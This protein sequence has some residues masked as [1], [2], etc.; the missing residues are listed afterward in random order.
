MASESRHPIDPQIAERFG[1][2]D[3]PV[4]DLETLKLRHLQEHLENIEERVRT[5]PKKKSHTEGEY[6]EAGVDEAPGFEQ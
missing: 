2:K 5:A 6:R 1:L 4:T 3:R